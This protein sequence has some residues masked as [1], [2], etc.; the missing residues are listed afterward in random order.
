MEHF[1]EANK[2][3]LRQFGL[4][5]GPLVIAIFGVLL[6]WLHGGSLPMVPWVI[7]VVL[8]ALALLVPMAL[9]PIYLI[10]IRIGFVLGWINTRLIL[11]LVF[12]GL[13]MPMGLFMRARRWDPM[14]QTHDPQQP[15][16][17]VLST[18]KAIQS[19]EK[20]Y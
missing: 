19:L 9:K 2:R 13:M 10:W 14:R 8:V 6:P 18:A 3:N 4:V 16:Y 12:Y 17:R 1:P 20:P 7:G 5:A 11:G 15:S